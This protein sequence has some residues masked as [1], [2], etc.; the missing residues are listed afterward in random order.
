[1]T[2]DAIVFNKTTYCLHLNN[3]SF[4]FA[5]FPKKIFHNNG[6]GAAPRSVMAM[7]PD[8][9]AGG[10][11]FKSR[12]PPTKVWRPNTPFICLFV[13]SEE[14]QPRALKGLR[15]EHGRSVSESLCLHLWG[16]IRYTRVTNITLLLLAVIAIGRNVHHEQEVMAQAP[17]LFLFHQGQS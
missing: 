7:T 11:G 17:K 15:T 3:M 2:F 8:S 10:P 1:M 16:S 14:V 12:C 9:H 4:V 6:E 5:F 13:C